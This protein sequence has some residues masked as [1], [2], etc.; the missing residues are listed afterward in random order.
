MTDQHE[1]H[2]HARAV[3]SG[4]VADLWGLRATF[5]GMDRKLDVLSGLVPQVNDHEQ[6]ISKLEQE[7]RSRTLGASLIRAAAMLIPGAL[8]SLDDD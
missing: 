1:P 4:Q 3:P 8:V 2:V 7:Q 6:R 5:E